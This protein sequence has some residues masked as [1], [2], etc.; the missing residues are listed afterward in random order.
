MPKK[1]HGWTQN[2]ETRS[3]T[4]SELQELM[5]LVRV[6]LQ[7]DCLFWLGIP[8]YSQI[9]APIYAIL[10]EI[11]MKSTST[12]YSRGRYNSSWGDPCRLHKKNWVA[13]CIS[14]GGKAVHPG[15]AR[16]IPL[17]I[18]KFIRNPPSSL[19]NGLKYILMTDV[20]PEI[21]GTTHQ[22]YIRS[23]LSKKRKI[24]LI[25]GQSLAHFSRKLPR[26][27]KSRPEIEIAD[28]RLAFPHQTPSMEP[29]YK[30]PQNR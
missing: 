12:W 15:V 9:V 11:F 13:A 18:G 2:A 21:L 20:L 4:P 30:P 25:S 5:F 23:Q 1:S 22:P 6:L 10:T 24:F 7:W 26:C 27:A 17:M 28:K 16:V 19:Q 8:L 14:W 29:S 3:K